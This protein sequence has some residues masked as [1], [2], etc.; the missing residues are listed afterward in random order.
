[1]LFRSINAL[2]NSEMPGAQPVTQPHQQPPYQSQ[3]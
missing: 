1:V 3:K 2:E